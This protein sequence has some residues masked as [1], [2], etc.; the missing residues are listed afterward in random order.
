MKTICIK[1]NN[2]K[3]LN[4]LL[5]NFKKIELD[6]IYFSCHKFNIYNNIFI[7]YKGDNINTFFNLVSNILAFLVLDIYEDNITNKILQNE[8]FYF[9]SLEREDILNIFRDICLENIEDFEI[10]ETLLLDCFNSFFK[11]NHFHKNICSFYLNGFITFRL[12]SYISKLEQMIDNA[13]NRYLIEKEYTEFV[14]LL[15]IYVNSEKSKTDLVH[16]VYRC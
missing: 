9:D 14:S 6:D 8:Y 2:L 1:T 15:K 3:A 5:E 7:H 4:Y 10:R 12:K 16:L 13:V 11:Q